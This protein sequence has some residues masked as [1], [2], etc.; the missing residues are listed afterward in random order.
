VGA[1]PS[2]S[3]EMTLCYV[4]IRQDRVRTD[5]YRAAITHHQKF[6]EGKVCRRSSRLIWVWVLL[7]FFFWDL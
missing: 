5:A 3:G 7:S 6:I 2:G 1:V 4:S